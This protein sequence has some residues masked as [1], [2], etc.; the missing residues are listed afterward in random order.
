M[1]KVIAG[2]VFNHVPVGAFTLAPV[3]TD[4]GTFSLTR[5]RTFT[6]A[7]AAAF[8]I[9]EGATILIRV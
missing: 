7:R 6:P 9:V 4:V 2:K 8:T 3:E 5:I 1:K